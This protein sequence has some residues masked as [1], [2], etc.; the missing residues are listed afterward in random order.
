MSAG[1]QHRR[2]LGAREIAA[3]GLIAALALLVRL[4]WIPVARHE[5]DG[6]E[7]EYLGVFLGSW[8]GAWSTRVVPLLGLLSRA[9]GQ[10]SQAPWLLVALAV[11]AS[12]VG[13]LCL[14][15][16][17]LVLYGNQA[18]W[19][20]SAYHVIH[21]Q[22][23]LWLALYL[24]TRG[25][26]PAWLLSGLA[27]GLAVGMRPELAACLLPALLLAR[28]RPWRHRLAWL[29]AAVLSAAPALLLLLRSGSHPQG[30]A[31]HAGAAL[32]QNLLLLD[33]L[34]PFDDLP[35]LLL[36]AALVGLAARRR[37]RLSAL[38]LG[39]VLL[40]WLPAAALADF[41]FRHAL[42]AGSSL[43]ALA[44]VGIAEAWRLAG[45]RPGWPGRAWRLAAGLAALAL[46]L[47]LAADTAQLAS[48]YYAPAAPLTA[49]LRAHNPRPIQGADPLLDGCQNVSE[50]PPIPG[51]LEPP[52]LEL[53][54]GF[55]GCVLW[56]EEYQHR[57]WSSRGVHDRGLR[58][59]RLY[60][61]QPLGMRRWPEDP[62]RPE[63]QVWRLLG[64]R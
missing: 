18:F 54:P 5:F 48:S 61:R 46:L 1:G 53:E 43:C 11:L 16:L 64:R 28:G 9:L 24:A 17:A 45:S 12:L 4:A 39:L 36:C 58:M 62:G 19:S 63:R 8:S 55:T 32:R 33:F 51:Q 29:G 40:T 21:P 41:G 13:I 26:L 52:Q 59:H 38:L 25:S 7:G 44:A 14:C 47:G 56:E 49:A 3:A 23:L 20:T 15:G 35:L 2:P 37:P 50:E 30:L 34:A 42:T 31:S 27:F 22:A 6:H 57:R 10:L 60:R